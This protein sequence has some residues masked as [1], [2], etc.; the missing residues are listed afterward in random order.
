M[1]SIYGCMSLVNILILPAIRAIKEGAFSGWPRLTTVILSDG[2]EEIGMYAFNGCT[3]LVHITI[4]P[5]A[6]VIDKTAFPVR[7]IKNGAFFGCSGLMTVILSDGLDEIGVHAFARCMS[8]VH[9]TIPP[10]VRAIKQGAFNICSGLTAAI[11]K[12][13]V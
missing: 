3:S 4:P 11:L 5:A 7:V 6:T 12:K 10:A 13:W 2:L 1:A 8:L 9:I